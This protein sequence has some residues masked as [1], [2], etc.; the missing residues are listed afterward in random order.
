[1]L[2]PSE[3]PGAGGVGL[4]GTGDTGAGGSGSGGLNF[5]GGGTVVAT[6]GRASAEDALTAFVDGFAGTGGFFDS[7]GKDGVDSGGM[8]T[9]SSP[10]SL[11]DPNVVAVVVDQ[12]PNNIGHTNG[13]FATVTICAP[14]TTN[15]QSIDHLLVDTGSVGL[16]L[17]ESVLTIPLPESKDSSG[18]ALAECVPFA[19]GAAWGPLKVANLQLAGE[20]A[21]ALP[22]QTI[23]ELTY[24]APANCPGQPMNDAQS[25]GANGILG[26]GVYMQD[27]GPSCAQ[28]ATSTTNP[29]LY[30]AC[31]SSQVGGCKIVSISLAQQVQNPVAVFPTDN[32]GTIIQLPDVPASGA[33]SVT[34]FLV[35]GIGT[36]VNNGLG[37]A[38]VLPLNNL[39]YVTTMFPAGGVYYSSYIDSGSDGIFF[40]NASTTSLRQC[41]GALNAY[42][43]PASTVSLTA[44][45]AG[46]G[47]IFADIN[48]SVANAS[49][50]SSANF[51]FSNLAGPMPGFPTDS[52]VPGFA[53]GLP[54]FFGRNVYTAIENQN[55]P[56]GYGPY[57]AF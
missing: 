52:T 10:Y 28:S 49:Q 20:R 50:A 32:N 26:V 18:A 27:C 37:G 4:G 42:Y 24:P 43:C 2:G 1:V 5:D 9:G 44:T 8:D 47:G 48:F 6:G 11:N 56:G 13:L 7:G 45:I 19:N 23:G 34:G 31:T 57:F 29:G 17:L 55:T 51:A 22:I 53:W 30:F 21:S 3:V 12:G 25:L 14:G 46:S 35:F 38:T 40:L 41:A 54:F 39:G 15:C 36:Q 16:R 33:P